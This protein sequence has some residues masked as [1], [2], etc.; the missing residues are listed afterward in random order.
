MDDLSISCT[1][2]GAITVLHVG[3]EVDFYSA[4][5]LGGALDEEI[6]TG[7]TRLVVDLQAVSF[8]DSSGLNVLVEGLRSVRPDNGS[9]GLVCS[10]E[11]ILKVFNSTGLDKLFAIS[12]SVAEACDAA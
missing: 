9:L 7:H 8:I 6:G 1:S 11:R 3:G 5:R 4:P 10:S 2:R 12:S